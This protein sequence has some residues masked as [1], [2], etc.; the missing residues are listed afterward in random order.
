M[1][2]ANYRYPIV[3]F[4]FEKEKGKNKEKT[5][6]ELI[7]LLSNFNKDEGLIRDGKK[8]KF[9]KNRKIQLLEYF[10]N[11]D[12]REILLKIFTPEQI[13]NFIEQNKKEEK[14]EKI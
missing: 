1:K 13:N 6:D 4:L 9:N 7:K 12:N 2:N 14:K 8:N 5:E 10:N 3:E 11:N